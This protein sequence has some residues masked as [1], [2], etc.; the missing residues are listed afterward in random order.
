MAGHMGPQ[1]TYFANNLQSAFQQ[2][3]VIDTTLKEEHKAGCTY[4]W[5]FKP[6]IFCTFGLGHIPKHNGEWQ[7]I[8]HLCTT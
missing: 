4:P 1:F 3:E 2:P 7:I 5:T 8:Y 6:H